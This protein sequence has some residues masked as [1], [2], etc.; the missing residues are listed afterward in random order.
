[1]HFCLKVSGSKIW[2]TER[3]CMCCQESGER[4]ASVSLFCPKAAADQP[5]VRKVYYCD[6]LPSLFFKMSSNLFQLIQ[7]VPLN[8]PILAI[9]GP[10]QVHQQVLY[11]SLEHAIAQSYRW[12][13]MMLIT[14][15]CKLNFSNLYITLPFLGKTNFRHRES[16]PGHLGESQIS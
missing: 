3:S 13:V 4:E 12:V 2:Q 9:K 11:R 14:I 1:M 15:C 5:K 16:N 6:S 8:Y 7:D 10:Q